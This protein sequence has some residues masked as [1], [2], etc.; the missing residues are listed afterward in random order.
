LDLQAK[1]GTSGCPWFAAKSNLSLIHAIKNSF[2]LHHSHHLKTIHCFLVAFLFVFSAAEV[3]AAK[4]FFSI[5]Q[6]SRHL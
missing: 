2:A 5:T 1:A 6:G 3:M 4:I